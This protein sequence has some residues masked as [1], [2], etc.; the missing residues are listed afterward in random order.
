MQATNL[1]LRPQ[2]ATLSPAL[3]ERLKSLRARCLEL[4]ELSPL[5]L[6]DAPSASSRSLHT[7]RS[8]P[9]TGGG[10]LTRTTPTRH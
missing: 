6:L 9:W 8:L 1:P 10:L 4:P 3:A 7:V 2:M 5:A